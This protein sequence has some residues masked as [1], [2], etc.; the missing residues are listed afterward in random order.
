MNMNIVIVSFIRLFVDVQENSWWWPRA[1]YFSGDFKR[2]PLLFVLGAMNY[3]S[4]NHRFARW[5][6]YCQAKLQNKSGPRGEGGWG[7]N[8]FPFNHPRE[9]PPPSLFLIAFY[10]SDSLPYFI[11]RNGGNGVRSRD[12]PLLP[13]NVHHAFQLHQ[14]VLKL[15]RSWKCGIDAMGGDD[16]SFFECCFEKNNEER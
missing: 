14:A 7:L 5:T 8:R 2:P 15:W 9:P 16:G 12:I 3:L 11:Q 13:I 6:A 4:W 10:E 1:E